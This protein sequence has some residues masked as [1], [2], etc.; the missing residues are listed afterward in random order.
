LKIEAYPLP[1]AGALVKHH[2]DGFPVDPE[3]VDFR[4]F[5]WSS[6]GRRSAVVK[7]GAGMAKMERVHGALTPC[8]F[9]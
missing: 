4:D 9:L 6:A 1:A 7:A 2:R 3:S 5:S 8:S